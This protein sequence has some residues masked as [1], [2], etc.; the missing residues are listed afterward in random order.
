MYDHF[1]VS[2]QAHM[3][4]VGE[5][6]RMVQKSQVDFGRT[7]HDYASHRAGFPASFFKKLDELGLFADHP[8]VLDIG[9][10][11]GTVARGFALRGCD[12]TGLDP[13]ESLI[14]EARVLDQK[15][16]VQIKYV[17]GTAEK[18]GLPDHDFDIIDGGAVFSHWFE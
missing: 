1:T 8:R 5:G 16:S 7:A 12:V 9:T 2:M 14:S 15:A 18:T 10:G 11:T 4:S 13:S 6:S 3:Y 17:T